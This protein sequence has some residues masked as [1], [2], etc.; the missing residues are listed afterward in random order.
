MPFKDALGLA[1]LL[2]VVHHITR[3]NNKDTGDHQIDQ[4]SNQ[5]FG[6]TLA[7]T[8]RNGPIVVTLHRYQLSGRW[9][10]ASPLLRWHSPCKLH[11]VLI[12]LFLDMSVPSEMVSL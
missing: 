6:A 10:S 3:A 1:P 5:W 9:S 2:H 11:D 8:G 12:R 4:K 7:S